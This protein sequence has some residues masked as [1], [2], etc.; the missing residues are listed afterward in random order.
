MRI[1]IA[2]SGPG[3]M[4]DYVSPVFGRCPTFT[5]VDVE[6]TQIKNVKVIQ[7]PGY[8]SSSGAGVLAAQEIVNEGCNVLISGSVGPNSYQVLSM[9]HVDM[10]SCSPVT[11]KDAINAFLEGRLPISV[12][13][14]GGRHG[15]GR[16][17][18][19]W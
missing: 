13:T 4:N 9:G 5:I 14:P 11:V 19:Q 2:T 3:G 1:C 6:G 10:R 18:G 17:F 7:N 8:Y 16:R 12:P 15:M